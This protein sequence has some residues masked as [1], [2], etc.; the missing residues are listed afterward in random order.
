MSFY[1]IDK[2]VYILN[3]IF[4]MTYAKKINVE[5]SNIDLSNTKLKDILKLCNPSEQFVLIE[6]YG[7]VSWKPM[8]MQQIWKKFDMSRERIR[9]ITNKSLW[10]VRRLISNNKDLNSIIEKSQ[11]ILKENGYILEE[12]KLINKLLEDKDVNI[13]YNEALLILSSD[14]ELYYIHRNKYFQKFFFLEPVFE[15]LIND[16]HNTTIK[17]L[18]E[19]KASIDKDMLIAKLSGLFSKKF[20]R[21]ETLKNILLNNFNYDELFNISK[22]I[23]SFNGKVWLYWDEKAHPRTMKLKIKYVLDQ[24]WKSTHFTEIAKEVKK[25]FNLK[26]VKVPSVHNELV[27]WK[28]FVNVWMWLY[29]LKKWWY[30]WT[31]TLELLQNVLK[32]S[33]RAMK[34]SELIKEV[35]KERNIKEVTILMVL[36]KHTDIFERVWKWLYQLKK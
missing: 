21:N 26:S 22:D 16:I 20:P 8:P 36:Q 31:N 1:Y 2:Q 11:K 33:W 9:Q 19:N 18:K 27:K 3:I 10:K 4:I 7:L 30:K 34:V 12:K 6:K 23:Y 13:N 25:T 28:E 15:D 24:I 5:E 35:L 29:W 14:Y 32:K 17:I